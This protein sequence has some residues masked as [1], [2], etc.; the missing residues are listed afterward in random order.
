MAIFC[1]DP[2]DFGNSVGSVQTGLHKNKNMQEF[3]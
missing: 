2:L 1:N 3:I